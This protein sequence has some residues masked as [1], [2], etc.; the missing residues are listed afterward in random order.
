MKLSKLAHYG[1]LIAIPFFI[2]SVF[3]FYQIEHKSL[4][5]IG[6][7]VFLLIALVFDVYCSIL[8]LSKK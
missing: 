2:I 1:D 6:I 8:F 3:Y 7:M 4:L 5:E